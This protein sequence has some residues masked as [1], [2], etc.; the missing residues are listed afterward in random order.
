M[1]E[2]AENYEEMVDFME[3]VTKG[4]DG[5]VIAGGERMHG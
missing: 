2:Q 3:K 4:D 5:G 1:V